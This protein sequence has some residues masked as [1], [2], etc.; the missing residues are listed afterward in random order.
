L[1]SST[2]Y[3][4]TNKTAGEESALQYFP[5]TEGI[6]FIQDESGNDVFYFISKTH[7][8]LVRL[9][10]EDGIKVDVDESCSNSQEQQKSLT[11]V[12]TSTIKG[13]FAN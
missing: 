8:K 3:W 4:S 11:W 12:A 6:D 9:H 1:E 5:N 2:Y 7:H 10:L 13:A